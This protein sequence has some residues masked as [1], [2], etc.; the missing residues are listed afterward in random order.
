MRRTHKGYDSKATLLW[1]KNKIIER[2][3]QENT[4]TYK[5]H[6]QIHAYMYMYASEIIDSN[7]LSSL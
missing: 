5:K 2:K 7:D 6:I 3:D 4:H 1:K